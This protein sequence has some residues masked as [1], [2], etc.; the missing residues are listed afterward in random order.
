MDNRMKK[1]TAYWQGGMVFSLPFLI[2][3]LYLLLVL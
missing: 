1:R 2:I 3:I